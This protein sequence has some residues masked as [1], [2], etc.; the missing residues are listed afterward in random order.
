MCHYYHSTGLPSSPR[1]TRSVELGNAV[2]QDATSSAAPTNTNDVIVWNNNK[3]DM[4][5]SCPRNLTVFYFDH[6]SDLYE[7]ILNLLPPPCNN[8]SYTETMSVESVTVVMY[9]TSLT[10]TSNNTLPYNVHICTILCVEKLRDSR[11]LEYF[12][13]CILGKINLATMF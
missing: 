1:H 7:V 13:D 11:Y 8:V 5:S 12:H 3:S 2:A 6:M 4:I 9:F 10:A